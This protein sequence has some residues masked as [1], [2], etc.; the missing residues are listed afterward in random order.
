M[1]AGQRGWL[2]REG[3]L[4]QEEKNGF[5]E[6]NMNEGE[7]NALSSTLKGMER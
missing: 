4:A 5:D 3:G 6:L 1:G 7:E 2:F